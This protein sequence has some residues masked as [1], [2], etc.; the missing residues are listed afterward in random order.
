[1]TNLTIRTGRSRH[2]LGFTLIELLV[3][4]AIIA[5]LAA[6]LFPVFA[7]AREAARKTACLSNEKQIGLGARMY[8]ED[9]DGGLYHHHEG[10]VLDDGTQVDTLPSSISGCIGGGSGN[11]NAEKPWAIFFQPYMKSR[12]LCF[13]P[14]DPAPR[15]RIL[16]NNLYDYNGAITTIGQE[17]AVNPSG[18]QCVAEKEHTAMWSYLLN[19]IFTHKSCRY[20]LEGALPGFATDP[21]ISSLT[22]PNVIMFSERNSVALDDPNNADFGYVPQDD[23]DTWPGE[24]ALVRWGSG[25][26]ANEGWVKF[27]SHNGGANYVYADGHAK[28]MRWGRARTDQ[29]PDHR[30]RQPLL[31]PPQ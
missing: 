25:P 28:F 17:C 18:E 21:V 22:D 20:V 14:S 23:Y 27:D 29:F 19:S 5:I 16:S 7:Q 11:S 6:I 31:S 3:V 30:V 15:S 8:M 13:C 26:H 9:F 24:A 10:Y 12:N 4:I 2:R 1:M